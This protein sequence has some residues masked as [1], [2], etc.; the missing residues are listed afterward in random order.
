MIDTL[1]ARAALPANRRVL[2]VFGAGFLPIMVIATCAGARA[3]LI[4]AG[5][6][7][8]VLLGL[9]CAADAVSNDLAA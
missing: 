3:L 4:E 1:R 2:E 6:S 7:L 8:A 9:A 5:F